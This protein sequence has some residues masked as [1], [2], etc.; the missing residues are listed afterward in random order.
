MVFPWWCCGLDGS[1]DREAAA[2]PIT[3]PAVGDDGF[4]K[5]NKITAWKSIMAAGRVITSRVGQSVCYFVSLDTCV[6]SNPAECYL[7]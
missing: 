4:A 7:G 5:V 2:N 3:I 1:Q 6:T